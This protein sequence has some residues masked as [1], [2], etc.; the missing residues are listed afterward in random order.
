LNRILQGDHRIL[1]ADFG[2]I[3]DRQ[4]ILYKK[5]R[6]KIWKAQDQDNKEKLTVTENQITQR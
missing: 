3:M 4:L 1:S 5:E 6:I 2:R